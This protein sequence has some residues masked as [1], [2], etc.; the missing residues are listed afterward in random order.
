MEGTT[1]KTRKGT[2]QI[3]ERERE[4]KCRETNKK[5]KETQYQ[6]DEQNEIY[7]R[8]NEKE[9]VFDLVLIEHRI[10]TSSWWTSWACTT[11]ICLDLT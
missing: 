6:K 1:Q 9:R 11:T 2:L 7:H 5:T 10:R 3:R 4:S 8:I